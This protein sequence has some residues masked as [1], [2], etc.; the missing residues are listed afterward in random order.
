MTDTSPWTKHLTFPRDGRSWR[1]EWVGQIVHEPLG[2]PTALAELLIAPLAKTSSSDIIP[3]IEPDHRKRVYL[4]LAYL[5]EAPIGSIWRD[6]I[7]MPPPPYEQIEVSG[8]RF[9][10]GH[11]LSYKL[12]TIELT[13][14]AQT[15]ADYLI[16]HFNPE[17][18]GPAHL[19]RV[20]VTQATTPP[21]RI[22]IPMSAIASF[23]YFRSPHTARRL[24][25]APFDEAVTQIYDSE[26]SF[27]DPN[28]GIARISVL[29]GTR[30]TDL[31]LIA[32][33]LASDFARGGASRIHQRLTE[34]RLNA[35]Y[36]IL[37]TFPPVPG[38]LK[39]RLKG[40]HTT[41]NGEPAFIAFNICASEFPLPKGVYKIEY[42]S[43]YED[44]VRGTHKGILKTPS[45]SAHDLSNIHHLTPATEGVPP[46]NHTTEA[47]ENVL[48]PPKIQ[49]VARRHS[50]RA[51][52]NSRTVI[53]QPTDGSSAAPASSSSSTKAPCEITTPINQ[54]DNPE[55]K[56]QDPLVEFDSLTTSLAAHDELKVTPIAISE[57][58]ITVSSHVY[59]PFPILPKRSRQW[60]IVEPTRGTKRIRHALTVEIAIR[61]QLLYLLEMERRG[62]EKSCSTLLVWKPSLAPIEGDHWAC[63]LERCV[64]TKGW[65]T[66]TQ[67]KKMGL[68]TRRFKH[69]NTA[70]NRALRIA[71]AVKEVAE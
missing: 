34:Y 38:P 27:I 57:P 9:N 50:P 40:F 48:S 16:P 30:R 41:L 44:A 28:T 39:M 56:T 71:F 23:F 35:N 1:V 7:R 20:I 10:F 32:N 6:G 43:P 65:P 25:T 31:L 70:D 29:Q 14:D 18:H 42:E 11:A 15:L 54:Q 59:S 33:I 4:E 46:T 64:L 12:E 26:H 49:R 51:R 21:V 22:L 45:A 63:F 53:K 8:C 69:S 24:A 61:G 68:E 2:H 5:S 13:P 19:S 37:E 3:Q 36:G 55:P 66:D 47:G 62:T 17:Q 60:S 67:I 58:S 52:P